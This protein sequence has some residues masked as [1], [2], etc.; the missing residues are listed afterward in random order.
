MYNLYDEEKLE[1]F[2]FSFWNQGKE[3]EKTWTEP[4]CL[5]RVNAKRRP[6]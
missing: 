3:K 2:Y 4:P 5:T 1:Y 6:A